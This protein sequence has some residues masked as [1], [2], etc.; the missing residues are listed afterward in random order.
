MLDEGTTKRSGP[1]IA[2]AIEDVGGQLDVGPAG[3]TVRVLSPDRALGLDLLIDVLSPAE[4]SEGFA[5]TQ[6]GSNPFGDR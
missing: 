4:L 3:A 2:T 5:G 6:T 1:E